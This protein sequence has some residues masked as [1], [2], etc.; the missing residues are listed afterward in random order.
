[1][2]VQECE[3][4]Q[5]LSLPDSFSRI[6]SDNCDES[7]QRVSSIRGGIPCVRFVALFFERQNLESAIGASRFLLQPFKEA[8]LAEEVVASRSYIVLTMSARL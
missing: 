2:L 5:L 7:K 8:V 6:M 4:C 3:R 1:V